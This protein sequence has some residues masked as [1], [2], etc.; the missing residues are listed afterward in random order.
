MMDIYRGNKERKQ[1]IY[2][3]DRENVVTRKVLR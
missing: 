2:I 3:G 1:L